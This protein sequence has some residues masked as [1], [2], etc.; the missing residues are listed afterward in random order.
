MNH[1]PR[2]ATTLSLSRSFM[3]EPA[4]RRFRVLVAE[5]GLL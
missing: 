5:K 1:Q 4:A 3:I 2:R